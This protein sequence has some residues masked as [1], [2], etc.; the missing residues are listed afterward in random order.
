MVGS[1]ANCHQLQRHCTKKESANQRHTTFF[2]FFLL[3]LFVVFV[4]V[5][6][7][8]GVL[9]RVGHALEL[10][11]YRVLASRFATAA[12]LLS[13]FALLW[14]CFQAGPCVF[15]CVC[16]FACVVVISLCPPPLVRPLFGRKATK[17]VPF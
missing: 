12:I 4:V 13:L 8:Q 3:C 17:P 1:A 2:L 15:V 6:M 5:S 7:A 9:G 11:A 16:V 10:A 14:G